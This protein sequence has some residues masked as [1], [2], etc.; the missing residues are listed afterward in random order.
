MTTTPI[1][2]AVDREKRARLWLFVLAAIAFLLCVAGTAS[3]FRD[4]YNPFW[5]RTPEAR[6]ARALAVTTRSRPLTDAESGRA[7]EPCGLGHVRARADAVP[8]VEESA[9]RDPKRGEIALE[10]IESVA[11]ARD[12]RVRAAA[13]R[14]LGRIEA[15]PAPT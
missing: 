7:L 6:E 13:E 8:V 4:E 3:H 9:K 10:V 14:L 1:T 5:E 12:A 2:P 11:Q 15:A